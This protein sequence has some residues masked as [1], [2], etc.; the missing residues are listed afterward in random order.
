MMSEMSHYKNRQNQP[1]FFKAYKNILLSEMATPSRTLLL[2]SNVRLSRLFSRQF[3]CFSLYFLGGVGGGY[4]G[5]S[6]QSNWK[7]VT[8]KT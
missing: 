7:A 6:D 8:A 4:L 5:A 3:L 1:F 2:T